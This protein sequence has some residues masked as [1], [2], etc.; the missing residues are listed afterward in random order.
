MEKVED[1]TNASR[2]NNFFQICSKCKFCCCKDARPP[3]TW[4]RRK[5]IENYLVVQGLRIEKPFVNVTYTFL[6]KTSE[7]FCILFDKKTGKCLVHSVKPET[8]VAG[9][10]T[11]DINLQTGKIEWFLKSESICPVAGILYKDKEALE[12]HLS[13]AKKELQTLIHELNVEALCT[14]LKIE[15]PETF[16]IGEESLSPEILEKIT[17]RKSNFSHCTSHK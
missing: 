5:I 1:T 3:V 2:Q 12:K 14:L 13:S 6:R 15:E 10:V 8:C 7:G 4:K 9:P 11:F 17:K 16:K